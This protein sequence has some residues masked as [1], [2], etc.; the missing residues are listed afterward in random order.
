MMAAPKPRGT[1]K[2]PTK[3]TSWSFSRYIDYRLCPFKAKLKYL[4]KIA[5]PKNEAMERGS[6][7]HELAEH[8][9]KGASSRLPAELK[10]FTDEF[11]MLRKQYKKAI[12]GMVVEDSWAFT[13]EWDETRWDNWVGCWVR[14]KLDCAHHESDDVMI[15]T[16]W[17]TGKFHQDLHDDYL[18]QL[19]LY[20]LAALL[21]HPH[22]EAVKPRLCYLDQDLIFPS[23]DEELVYTRADIPRLKKLWNKRV[24]P[25][26]NDTRFPPRPN[27]KC[28]WCFYRASNKAGGGGQCKF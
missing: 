17:K 3:F 27:N 21:L 25:M 4:D 16:D 7:I 10:G 15:V 2:K 22:L 28:R 6:H 13:K 19:E 20:A 1:F 5:E 9:I 14:I 11:K 12:S 8:Y 26:M 24:R 23:H 18:E